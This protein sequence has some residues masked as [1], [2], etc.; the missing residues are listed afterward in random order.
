MSDLINRHDAIATVHHSI[1]D[2]FDVVE[3][4]KESPITEKDKMLLELN[5]ALCNN[6]KELPSAERTGRWIFKA[7]S[8]GFH[9]G[10]YVCS[11][12]GEQCEYAHGDDYPIFTNYCPNCGA[13]MRGEENGM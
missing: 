3:D 1:F 6:I 4:D 5:K 10:W 7:N 11:E 8:D 2:F 13:D 9:N 12:C